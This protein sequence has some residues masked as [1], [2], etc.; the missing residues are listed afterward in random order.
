MPRKSEV[1]ADLRA[2][3]SLIGVNASLSRR[4]PSGMCAFHPFRFNAASDITVAALDKE[5]ELER[6]HT[7]Q[8]GNFGSAGYLSHYSQTIGSVLFKR[9]DARYSPS[10][11]FHVYII[12]PG[13]MDSFDFCRA[14]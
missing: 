8:L 3:K 4:S 2:I 14:N 10:I 5:G 6:K 12:K 13:E 11:T 7:C 9:R 1:L